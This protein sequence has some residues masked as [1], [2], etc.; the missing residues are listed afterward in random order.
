MKAALLVE[1]N[2]P[3]ELADL[4][5]EPLEYGQVFVRVIASGICGAQLQEIRGEKGTHFPRLMGHEG[6][7]EV[8]ACGSGVTH[9]KV[10]DKVVMHWRKGAGIESRPPRYR[11]NGRSITG[12][13]V[14][15]FADYS[16]CSENRLTAVPSDTAGTFCALL[17][18]GL[19]TA[20][21]V[22]ENDAALRFGERIFIIGCGGLGLNL[23][24]AARLAQAS[25]IAVTD[26][27]EAKKA[28]ARN[29]G[30]DEF[31]CAPDGEFDVVVDTTGVPSAISYGLTRLAP[32]GRFIMVGQPAPGAD[33]VFPKARAMFDGEGCVIKATQ[34][35][36]FVPHKDIPRY[37]ALRQAGLLHLNG[38]ITHNRS[39]HEINDA[40]TLVRGGEAGRILIYP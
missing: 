37:V 1:N 2:A 7:G 8:V 36:G 19:S 22:I 16:V 26:V 40:I 10:G 15:T 25:R 30:A 24:R 13:Q 9:V 39:L 6:V 12:G 18:C 11:L 29:A 27:I 17:G 23:I 28:A 31:S 38:I 32:S 35:G 5:P 4:E 20:L 21:G 14:V 33:V 34:G 3:L